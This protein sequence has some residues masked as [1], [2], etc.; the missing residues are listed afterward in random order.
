MIGK[1]DL[2]RMPAAQSDHNAIHSCMLTRLCSNDYQ[3]LVG[4]CCHLPLIM[5]FY[6]P[7]Y[8]LYVYKW[9]KRF[10]YNYKPKNTESRHVGPISI[11][12]SLLQYK[13]SIDSTHSNWSLAWEMS[14]TSSM[15]F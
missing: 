1:T 7:W 5:S 15:D 10:G 8:V 14:L 3:I 12:Q 9:P 13:H 6:S 2:G 4:T 11:L